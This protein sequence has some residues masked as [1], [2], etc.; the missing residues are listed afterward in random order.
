MHIGSTSTRMGSMDL[1]TCCEWGTVDAFLNKNGKF[2][3]KTLSDKTGWW[4]FLLPVDI[5]NDGDIDLV[6]GNLGLNSRLKAS[7]KEPIK[8]Y[9]NDFDENGKK[10]QVLTYFLEGREIPFSN[11]SELEKQIPNL[12]KKFLYAEDFAKATLK[13]LFGEDK[14]KSFGD[15][16]C[17][18]SF[19]RYPD[20]R[21]QYEFSCSGPSLAGATDQLPRCCSVDFNA[22]HLP[23]ILLVGNYY[24]N[25]IQ[26]GSSDADFGIVLI[27][28]GKGIV[29][30]E[31]VNGM[32]LKG[33]I[34]HI[35]KIK[36]A[37]E[38]ALHYGKEQ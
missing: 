30:C 15:S 23:D 34:R 3:R 12:K 17:E 26:L 32:T 24:D 35:G 29:D 7:D 37:G 27:N 13:E 4:N 11:K 31:T 28:K 16:D 1:I 20:Q 38:E 21:W 18:L 8:L 9:Y 2:I 19:Q 14:L 5:D 25:N 36:L 6:A 33:Q 10:E 22:D